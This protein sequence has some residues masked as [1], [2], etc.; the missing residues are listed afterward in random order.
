MSNEVTEQQARIV[1]GVDGSDQSKLAL[2]WAANL[3]TGFGA[4]ID[5]VAAWQ[6]PTAYGWSSVVDDWNPERDTT[7]WLADT[8]DEVFGAQRPKELRLLVRQGNAAQ[9]LLSVSAN[10][11]ERSHCPVLVVHGDRLPATIIRSASD[12]VG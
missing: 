2:R 12:S 6:M 3:A 4:S 8:V 10:C 7:K 11:A 9:V 1:V 5:A